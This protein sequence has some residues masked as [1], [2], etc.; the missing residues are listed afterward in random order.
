MKPAPPPIMRT[1]LVQR[2]AEVTAAFTRTLRD[3]E[4]K[5][6]R[7]PCSDDDVG[8]WWLSEDAGERRRA[9]RLCV[10][11]PVRGECLAAA[12]AR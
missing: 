1:V 2:G 9:A 5:G 8:D 12:E 7:T 6:L 4:L 3:L 11:C 10:P